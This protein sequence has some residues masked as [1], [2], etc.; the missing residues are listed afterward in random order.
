MITFFHIFHFPV[1]V[2]DMGSEFTVLAINVSVLFRADGTPALVEVH[3]QV[4]NNHSLSSGYHAF[5][6]QP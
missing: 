4:N 6:V 3:V 1:Y 2:G 5:I